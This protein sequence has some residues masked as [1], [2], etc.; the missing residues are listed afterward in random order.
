MR[1]LFCFAINSFVTSPHAHKNWSVQIGKPSSVFGRESHDL[2]ICWLRLYGIR[3]RMNLKIIVWQCSTHS[4]FFFYVFLIIF[5]VM[6]YRNNIE[7][8]YETQKLKTYW[9]HIEE[10]TSSASNHLRHR[11]AGKLFGHLRGVEFG[12]GRGGRATGG[13][14][15]DPKKWWF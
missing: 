2:L 9:K 11:L 14:L 15:D 3:C 12:R 13:P 8:P 4:F 6:D 1:F 5:M 10:T 7:K